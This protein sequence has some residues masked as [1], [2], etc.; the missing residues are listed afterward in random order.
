MDTNVKS[1]SFSYER[2]LLV[3][4][5][6]FILNQKNWLIGITGIAGLLFSF[7]LLPVILASGNSTQSGFG[8]SLERIAMFLYFAGGLALTSHIFHEVHS[9]NTSYQFLTLP[10]T[11]FEKFSAAWF[12][13]AIGYTIAA[14]T[15]IVLLSFSVE[16]VASINTGN[17]SQFSLFNPFRAD[18]LESVS[19]YIMFQSIFLLGAIYF[20][21][22]NFLKTLLV[23]IIL[24][25]G[26][27][28]L[29]GIIFLITGITMQENLS[30]HMHFEG[31][32]GFFSVLWQFIIGILF[33]LFILFL[34][35]LQLK[36]KQ[37]A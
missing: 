21:K 2:V 18:I 32:T 28:L 17:W 29:A 7:W 12:V 36:N 34:A 25:F 4:K 22:N 6:F 37:V 16:I 23:Y 9:P 20:R 26:L 10:A 11:N 13:S 14:M 33:T 5:R 27:L 15:A 35:Y 1:S 31:F 24:V 30:V 19:N 8:S 3:S